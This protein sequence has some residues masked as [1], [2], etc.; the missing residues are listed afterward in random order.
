MGSLFRRN[1]SKKGPTRSL[2]PVHLDEI[3]NVWSDFAGIPRPCW[4]TVD[5]WVEQHYSQKDDGQVYWKL[6]LDWLQAIQRALGTP[7]QCWE[8]EHFRMLAPF[9][10]T[11]ARYQLQFLEMCRTKIFSWIGD[12]CNLEDPYPKVVIVLNGSQQ[13]WEYVSFFGVDGE[14]GGSI[15]C[16]LRQGY[17]HIALFDNEVQLMQTTL[18][19]ELVHSFLSHRGMPLWLEEG[20]CGIFPSMVGCEGSSLVTSPEDVSRLRQLLREPGILAGVWNGEAFASAR[21]DLQHAAYHLAEVLIRLILDQTTG[22]QSNRF[23]QDAHFEDAGEAAARSHLNR[24]LGDFAATFLGPG[25]WTPEPAPKP[26]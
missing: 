2:L 22:P 26:L 11:R 21:V 18:A 25:Q 4:D 20:L 5:D 17:P 16:N 1:Q 14:Q 8:T 12:L 15:G 23:L 6:T 13:Y 10:P 19:H 3:P 9:S 7:F 24:S